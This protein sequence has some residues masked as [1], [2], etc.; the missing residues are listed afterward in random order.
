M[1]V[2]MK[3]FL[4]IFI[5]F[6][7][8]AFGSFFTTKNICLRKNFENIKPIQKQIN[9]FSV[10]RN[11][12]YLNIGDFLYVLGEEYAFPIFLHQSRYIKTEDNKKEL[13]IKIMENK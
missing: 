11:I 9:S 12:L 2:P 8:L 13:F 4:I 7:L 10:T 6:L 5:T 3:K 1:W